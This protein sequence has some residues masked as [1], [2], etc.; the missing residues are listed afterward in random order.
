MY[1]FLVVESKKQKVALK[2]KGMA[3]ALAVEFCPPRSRHD[4]DDWK[5]DAFVAAQEAVNMFFA[6][7][8]P[9]GWTL[10]Q[11]VW[12]R[13]RR[14]LVRK[15]VSKDA[16]NHPGIHSFD[17]VIGNEDGDD[18]KTLRRAPSLKP[19]PFDGDHYAM[20]QI[21]DMVFAE[22]SPSHPLHESR[23]IERGLWRTICPQ[24]TERA[25]QRKRYLQSM[26]A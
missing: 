26:V 4:L 24:M 21:N 13:I 17:D 8:A 1:F 25:N 22:I 11:Y 6:R 9:S 3:D 15:L 23:K 2:Y 20:A 18:Q 16:L 19:K 12:V 10:G 7:Y 14:S 5:A